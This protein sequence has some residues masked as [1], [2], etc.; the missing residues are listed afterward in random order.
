MPLVLAGAAAFAVIFVLFVVLLFIS[1]RYQKVGP[2][3][4]LIISGRGH[5][6]VNTETGQTERVGYRIVKGGGTIIWPVLERAERLDLDGEELFA[7]GVGGELLL[8]F[9]RVMCV[10]T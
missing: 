8:R 5:V 6:R 1:S 3:E 2:N 9:V 7:I 10:A 4:A